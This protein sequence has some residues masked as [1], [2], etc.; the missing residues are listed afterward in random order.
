MGGGGETLQDRLEQL[1]GVLVSNRSTR[2]HEFEIEVKQQN[3]TVHVIDHSSSQ[4]CLFLVLFD[5]YGEQISFVPVSN[6][7]LG[8]TRHG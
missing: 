3:R 8:P 6:Y 2:Q 1:Q 7:D 5:V 4:D